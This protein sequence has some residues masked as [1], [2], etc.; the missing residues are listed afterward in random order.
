MKKK[1]YV[2]VTDYQ[3]RVNPHGYGVFTTIYYDHNA[4]H[5]TASTTS[6]LL[7][8]KLKNYKL[9][10]FKCTLVFDEEGNFDI[11]NIE[12]GSK[13][14]KKFI[15]PRGCFPETKEGWADYEAQFEKEEKEEEDIPDDEVV[16]WQIQSSFDLQHYN[17]EKDMGAR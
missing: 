2:E 3:I 14:M 13:K 16:Q 5:K 4:E 6:M 15:R 11:E 8:E 10:P 1:I 7:A 12:E 17:R 9:L